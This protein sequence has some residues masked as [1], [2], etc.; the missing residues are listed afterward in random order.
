MIQNI[1]SVDTQ[2]GYGLTYKMVGDSMEPAFGEGDIIFIDR[3]M[4]AE[5]NDLVTVTIGDS[6][7]PIFGRLTVEGKEW[8]LKF[9][10]PHY[11]AIEILPSEVFGVVIKFTDPPGS[12]EAE[13]DAAA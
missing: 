11:P 3:T 4:R 1:E 5:P 6:R 10:N 13:P 8:F 12:E 9:L 2:D 7:S